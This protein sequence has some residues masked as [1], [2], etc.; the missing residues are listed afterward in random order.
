MLLIGVLLLFFLSL[1]LLTQGFRLL[2][3]ESAASLLQIAQ[4]PF[5]ALFLGILATAL[6]QSSSAT[7][8]MIVS[9]VA[10]GQLS[11]SGAVPMIMGANIGTS[12][13]ST[14][15]SLGYIGNP[16]EYQKAI[17]G[18][19]LHDIF[20]IITAIAL[21]GLELGFGALSGTSAWLASFV[22]PRIGTGVDGF[23]YYFK[24]AAM[25]V[26]GFLTSAQY[27]NGNPFLILPFALLGVFGSLQLLTQLMKEVLIGRIQRDI[28]NYVFG[29]SLRALFSGFISTTAV[30]SSSVTTSLIVPLVATSKVSLHRA[31]PFLMG[32]NLGTTTTALFA[33]IFV[34]AIDPNLANAGLAIA[35]AHVL[36][37]LFGVA[38]MYPFE[39]VRLLAVR[40]A[41][42]LGQLTLKNRLY[43]VAYVVLTFFVIPMLLILVFR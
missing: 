37:N 41:R 34:G 40:L 12:V 32:A 23:L 14:I 26:A 24:D 11:L 2:G 42:R 25:W 4:N 18:A 16:K 29:S 22:N 38:I 35:F 27:P 43:G 7:T 5:V 9:L 28:D 19:T 31:F 36:F 21:L 13:T 20:N 6:M 10:A 39:K 15:V 3:N 1:H 8:T 30:Q 33:A 17:S